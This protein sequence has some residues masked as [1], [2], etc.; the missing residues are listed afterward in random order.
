MLPRIAT[1]NEN[2]S[3]YLEILIECLYNDKVSVDKNIKTVLEEYLSKL[4]TEE[5]EISNGDLELFNFALTNDNLDDSKATNEV[6]ISNVAKSL[7]NVKIT[8]NS[9]HIYASNIVNVLQKIQKLE[10]F[11]EFLTKLLQKAV[12][13]KIITLRCDF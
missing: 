2:H 4:F 5:V 12:S 10:I 3:I 13:Y 9:V 6:F 11:N 1:S 8:S 7:L